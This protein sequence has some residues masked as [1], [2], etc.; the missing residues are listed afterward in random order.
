MF[1]IVHVLC[2]VL[3]GKR[4]AVGWH[5]IPAWSIRV[6][7][8][9]LNQEAIFAVKFSPSGKWLLVGGLSSMQLWNVATKTL[10]KQYLADDGE[11]GPS[12]V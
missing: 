5:P 4:S 12:V 3:L 8:S 9:L 1:A 7:D 10:E 11:E 2:R 6:A